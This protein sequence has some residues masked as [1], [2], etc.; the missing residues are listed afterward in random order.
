MYTWV[1]HFREADCPV[2]ESTSIGKVRRKKASDGMA[3]EARC[4]LKV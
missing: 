1:P 3:L 2:A 4:S